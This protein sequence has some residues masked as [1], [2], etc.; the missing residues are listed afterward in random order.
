VEVNKRLNVAFNSCAKYIYGVPRFRSIS[1]YS[2]QILG[3]PLNTYFEHIFRRCSMMYRLIT[4][5]CPGYLSDRL[6]MTTMNIIVPP[7]NKTP[8]ST[9]FFV[10]GNKGNNVPPVIKIKSSLKA[11]RESYLSHFGRT[12]DYM[13]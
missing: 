6:R 2:A 3:V 10:Q 5:R 1:S 12:V 7:F 13:Y 8:R 4:T 9:S 11:F